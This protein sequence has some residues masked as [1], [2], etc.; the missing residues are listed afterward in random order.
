M[1]AVFTLFVMSYHHVSVYV[2]ENVCMRTPLQL[3]R[4]N[5]FTM[6]A[7]GG[8]KLDEVFVIEPIPAPGLE[9]MSKGMTTSYT[10]VYGATLGQALA[11]DKSKLPN[12]FADADF[13]TNFKARCESAAR[14]WDR[15]W[16]RESL[17]YV[18]QICGIDRYPSHQER[19]EK[20]YAWN[21]VESKYATND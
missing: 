9:A 18:L 13:G 10:V 12:E 20:K 19:K 17:M 15:N 5:C 3:G 14:T 11:K 7:S 21:A 2:Y 16:P 8:G 6:S 4:A 1:D